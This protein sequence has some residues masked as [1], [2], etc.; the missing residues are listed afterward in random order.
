MA[1]AIAQI[2]A[3]IR[4]LQGALGGKSMRTGSSSAVFSAAS[5]QTATFAH[6]LPRVPS[7]VD[8]ISTNSVNIGFQLVSADAT[9]ATLRVFTTT[10]LNISATITFDWFAVG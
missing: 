1:D 5:N 10:G 9:N 6:G 4:Q 7:Y 2:Q 3:L 8:G